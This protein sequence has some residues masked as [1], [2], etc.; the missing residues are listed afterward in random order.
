MKSKPRIIW[1]QPGV[2][3]VIYFVILSANIILHNSVSSLIYIMDTGNTGVDVLREI[4]FYLPSVLSLA[5]PVLS[6][7]FVIV[8]DKILYECAV[9]LAAEIEADLTAK[10]GSAMKCYHNIC[11]NCGVRSTISLKNCISCGASLEII[12]SD[13]NWSSMRFLSDE[14]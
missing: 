6:F 4:V 11:P 12:G 13:T 8:R 3:I 9:R 2:W 5:C 10:A 7:I 1:L 14:D